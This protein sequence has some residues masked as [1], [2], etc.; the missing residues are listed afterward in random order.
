[1]DQFALR[2]ASGGAAAQPPRPQR[3]HLP[4]RNPHSPLSERDGVVAAQS[5]RLGP[6]VAHNAESARTSARAH[7]AIAN[8]PICARPSVGAAILDDRRASSRSF[9][10]FVHD[11]DGQPGRRYSAAI[12]KRCGRRPTARHSAACRIS[13]LQAPKCRLAANDERRSRRNRDD[14]R[15]SRG[16][17]TSRVAAVAATAFVADE[18]CANKQRAH[19]SFSSV[20]QKRKFNARLAHDKTIR[21]LR[22]F[23]S[24]RI[25]EPRSMLLEYVKHNYYQRWTRWMCAP[26][27]TLAWR[28]NAQNYSFI[29]CN[30]RR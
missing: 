14:E 22:C 4:T 18:R 6:L 8:R 5:A 13:D 3:P 7:C 9:S 23:S 15:Q 2:F 16:R 1:M 17:K 20:A 21:Q 28:L 10:L 30:N 11:D 25:I 19:I 12:C 26:H 24:Q 27:A 29:A